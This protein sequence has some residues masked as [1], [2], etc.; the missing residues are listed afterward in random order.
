MHA[1]SRRC[2]VPVT[3]VW[4]LTLVTSSDPPQAVRVVA[5]PCHVVRPSP[6]LSTSWTT[7]PR[8]H[9]P[10]QRRQQTRRLGREESSGPGSGR[11]PP[12]ATPTPPPRHRGS[13]HHDQASHDT[14]E[15]PIMTRLRACDDT[16]SSR[17]GVNRVTEEEEIMKRGR[18]RRKRKRRCFSSTM[19]GILMCILAL[20]KLVHIY[21]LRRA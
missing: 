15:A 4:S 9:S 5:Y 17:V 21:E 18:R 6:R 19:S 1:L 14:G 8:V 20:G 13:A 10:T 16:A 11:L 2:F 3:C 7:L 12:R